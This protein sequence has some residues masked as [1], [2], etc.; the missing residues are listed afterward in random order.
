MSRD[1]ASPELTERLQR[2]SRILAL[3]AEQLD[4]AR[5]GDSERLRQVRTERAMLESELELKSVQL[6]TG[7]RRDSGQNAYTGGEHQREELDRAESLEVPLALQADLH[8][9]L[10]LLASLRQARREVEENWDAIQNGAVRTARAVP[11][12]RVAPG[13]YAENEPE[14]PRVDLRL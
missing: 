13:R 14:K 4:A 3:I 5:S 6:Q 12:L 8:S 10:E 11:V 9:A 1:A 7:D 2:Y